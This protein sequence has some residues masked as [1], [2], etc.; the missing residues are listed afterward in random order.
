MIADLESVR[1]TDL[2]ARIG[3]VTCPLLWL[4]GA[5]DRMVAAVDGR[6]GTVRH[7]EGVGHLIPVEAPAAVA[8][9]VV[10]LLP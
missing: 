3:D 6:P 7:L 8:E 10:E 9:A 2:G 4:D 1:A 5:D